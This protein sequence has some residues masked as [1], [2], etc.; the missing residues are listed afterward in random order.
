MAFTGVLGTQDSRLGNF[1]L[2][3]TSVTV[4]GTYDE[5]VS[6]DAEVS[7]V[8]SGA[9]V[10]LHSFSCNVLAT[11]STLGGKVEFPTLSIDS[12]ASV[13]LL[14]GY[15][16]HETFDLAVL[17]SDEL[18]SDH[19]KDTAL[20]ISATADVTL[21]NLM[22]FAISHVIAAQASVTRYGEFTTNLSASLS[23]T[24]DFYLENIFDF[25]YVTAVSAGVEVS[26]LTEGNVG[27]N[28]SASG[29]FSATSEMTFA[30]TLSPVLSLV[31]VFV[32]KKS[33]IVQSQTLS[34][35]QSYVSALHKIR[36]LEHE[37]EF[38]SSFDYSRGLSHTIDLVSEYSGIRVKVRSLSHSLALSQ[39]LTRQIIVSRTVSDTLTFDSERQIELPVNGLIVTVPD[40]E[41]NL[42]SRKCT[43]ILS[44]STQ[45]IVLPCPVF[46]DSQTPQHQVHLSRTMTGGTY[47]YVRRSKTQKLS[48]T[49]ELWTHKFFEMENFFENH[50]G[51][52]FYLQNHNTE[53]WI[54]AFANNPLEF[55]HDERYQ[56][57]GEKVTVT[58]EFEGIKL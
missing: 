57:R 48:Y 11:L 36:T 26:E 40:W 52:F 51:R 15:G 44:S 37:I 29:S 49:F 16:Y 42:V 8:Q 50:V 53:K 17:A 1:V 3:Y 10:S 47:T 25:L 55:S 30:R 9:V 27:H 14:P 45:V 35:V 6:I 24:A 12:V 5:S 2:G 38:V 56:P 43:V 18:L 4:S 58:L 13:S 19:F 23:V 34:L 21:S 20:E 28:P 54:V 32:A 22:R 33:R 31:G 46:G 41:A 7:I 39:S